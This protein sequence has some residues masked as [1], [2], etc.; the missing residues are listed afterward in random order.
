M[1]AV[2]DEVRLWNTPVVG[3]FLL[4]N[5][6][7]GY[8]ENHPTGDAPIGLLHFVALAILT[9]PTLVEPISN[10]RDGLQSYAR[11]FEDKKCIDRLLGIQK[12]ID[13]K[14]QYTLSS[15]DVSI[16][17]GLLVWD[18]STG[19]IYPREPQK[20]PSRG[21]AVR[22]SM[23]QYG[24]KSEILGKWFSQHDLATIALYLKVVF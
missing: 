21:K 13:Q 24:K 14:K 23:K 1:G 18:T 9:D 8:V 4:W 7:K 17:T 3:A 20:K 11:S 19:K 15:I 12:Q 2:V 5:F 6:T 16:S 10:K 22:N